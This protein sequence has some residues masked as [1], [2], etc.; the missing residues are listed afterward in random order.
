MTILNTL[1]HCS[2]GPIRHIK[3][4]LDVSLGCDFAFT[5]LHVALKDVNTLSW[6]TN[7]V[8]CWDWVEECI[9]RCAPV[10]CK[11]ILVNELILTMFVID[12]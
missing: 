3:I 8:N 10:L 7:I 5:G 2:D 12:L 6:V 9:N 1:E 11:A 4:P